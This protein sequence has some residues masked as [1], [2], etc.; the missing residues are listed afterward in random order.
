[1]KHFKKILLLCFCL[2]VTFVAKLFAEGEPKISIVTEDLYP[3]NYVDGDDVKGSSTKLIKKT[4]NTL[5]WDSADIE[6]MPW[7]RAYSYA[8]N[9]PNILIYSMLRI[10]DREELF[11]WVAKVGQIK[12]GVVKLKSRKDINVDNIEDLN[13]YKMG[14]YVGSPI[15]NYLKEYGIEVSD[16]VGRYKSL[17]PMLVR[18]RIDV[19]PGSVASFLGEARKQGYEDKFEIIYKF[20]ELSK[21]LYC[22]FSD[23]TDDDI[24]NQFKDAFQK[25]NKQ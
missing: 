22:A 25:V 20:D 7:A 17:V 18:G 5:K 19:V 9:E 6:V 24:V 8:L 15:I 10:P 1:M 21:D 12:V 14:V 2:T 4:F 16:V 11:K 13:K 3:F 23:E